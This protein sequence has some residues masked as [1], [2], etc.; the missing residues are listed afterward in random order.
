MVREIAVARLGWREVPSA[1]RPDMVW[2]DSNHSTV[3]DRCHTL[4]GLYSGPNLG[5]ILGTILGTIWAP[6]GSFWAPFGLFFG[7]FW[8]L[9]ERFYLGPIWA[10]FGPYVDSICALFR[11]YLCSI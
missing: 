6:F 7:P 11:P 10:L 9:F 2:M 1:A 4:F 5:I 3:I 8:A